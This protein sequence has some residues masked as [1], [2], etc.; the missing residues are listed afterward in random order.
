V[1]F[2]VLV[3]KVVLDRQV[4]GHEDPEGNFLRG[5]GGNLLV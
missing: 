3:D 5:L 1:L 2:A 4:A